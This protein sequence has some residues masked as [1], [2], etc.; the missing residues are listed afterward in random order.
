MG[1]PDQSKT[2]LMIPS[3]WGLG[4]QCKRTGIPHESPHNLRTPLY[5]AHDMV[6]LK[7]KGGEIMFICSTQELYIGKNE[8][9]NVGITRK[10][11]VI[12]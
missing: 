1:D 8:Q 12:H 6:M 10:H 3:V 7:S 4:P 5:L 2:A 11:I 9:F